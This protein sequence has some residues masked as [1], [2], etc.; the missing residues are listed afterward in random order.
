MRPCCFYAKNKEKDG[1]ECPYARQEEN[2]FWQFFSGNMEFALQNT[3]SN[4]FCPKF[5]D[6]VK[7]ADETYRNRRKANVV[8]NKYGSDNKVE[9]V[10]YKR[11]FSVPVVNINDKTDKSRCFKKV[12]DDVLVPVKEGAT[13]AKLNRLIQKSSDRA[14]KNFN[15]YSKSNL[16]SYFFTFTFSPAIVKD[17]F[18]DDFIKACWRKIQRQLKY[19]D[20]DVKIM[21]V[22]ERHKN[23]ALHFHAP[24]TFSA[25]LPIVDYGDVSKLPQRTC[26]GGKDKGK[27]G[28]CT[29]TPEGRFTIMPSAKYKTFLVPYYSYGELQYSSLG[30]M[31]F[32][33]NNYKYGINSCAILPLDDTNQDRV[34][35][36]LSVYCTKQDNLG[37]NT[38]RFRH[39]RNIVKGTTESIY[40]NEEDLQAIMDEYNLQ[41]FKD[42]EKLQSCRNFNLDKTPP[43]IPLAERLDR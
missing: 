33:L 29:F 38:K 28:F 11:S 15:L 12:A 39:T 40:C 1:F 16:W 37:Y 20:S 8:L 32:C 6:C 41:L 3:S 22:H 34:G 31:L 24:I 2:L 23:G 42:T 21:E 26:Q 13:H 7:L 27:T 35:N 19:L 18:D 9:A 10:V 17:R 25:D 5:A 4:I 43:I 14:H 36:Y 30:D